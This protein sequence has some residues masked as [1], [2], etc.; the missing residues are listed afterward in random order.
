MSTQLI[1]RSS[2]LISNRFEWHLLCRQNSGISYGSF[3]IPRLHLLHCDSRRKKSRKLS[4]NE[5]D[6]I[7]VNAAQRLNF[8]NKSS[9]NNFKNS[10]RVCTLCHRSGHTIYFFY[11]KH[12][13]PNFNKHKLVVPISININPLW[14]QAN[15]NTMNHL[16][17]LIR[18]RKLL[19]QITMF[20]FLKLNMSNLLPCS[21]NWIWQP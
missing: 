14:M 7:L 20:I 21:D 19:L 1:G 17:M 4:A 16:N 15:L 6:S 2:H 9:F 5:D 3:P 10:T 12:G 13:R 11:Q 18:I 8:K